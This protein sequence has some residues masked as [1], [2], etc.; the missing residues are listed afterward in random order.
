M[1]GPFRSR[2]SATL[3]C[4]ASSCVSLFLACP[5]LAADLPSSAQHSLKV[6]SNR[7]AGSSAS[8]ALFDRNDVPRAARLAKLETNR[9]PRRVDGWF[10]A[11]ESASARN[12][13]KTELRSALDVCK[14]AKA[15]DPR[16]PIA[17]MRLGSF[18][19]NSDLLR[20]E[21]NQLEALAAGESVC[22]EAA[23]ETL[24]D[25][26]LD[27]LPDADV[28]TLSRRAG[29]LTTWTISRGGNHP[30]EQFEF[31]DAHVQL[32]DYFPRAATYEGATSFSA[33]AAGT[34]V[35]TGDLRGVKVSIDGQEVASS[36]LTLAAGNH[37]VKINFRA[38]EASPRIRILPAARPDPNWSNLRML[39]REVLYIRAADALAAGNAADAGLDLKNPEISAMTVA[40][41][42]LA[43]ATNQG[44][45]AGDFESAAGHP[46]CGNLLAALS[47]PGEPV[48]AEKLQSCAPDSL[49][50][51]RWLATADRHADVIHELQ[52]VL[53]DWPLDREAHR[54][55]I[56]ELQRSGNAVAADRAAAAFLS[57]APNARNFRRMAQT[58]AMNEPPAS[59]PFY[60]AYRRPAPSKLSESL[61]APAVILLQDKVA[62][63]RVDGSVS[64]YVHR[65]VQL[66]TSAGA[67]QFQSLAL[68]EGGQLLAARVVNGD[69]AFP[70]AMKP[71]DE[72][73]EEYVVNYT[74]DGGMIAHP[75]A[76]QYVFHDFDYPLLNA[77][78]VVLSPAA[79]SPG[80]VIASGSV[81]EATEGYANGFRAQ[82]WEKQ[83]QPTAAATAD[84][85]II[86]VVENENGWSI[87]PSVERRRILE[88]IHPG[89]RPREA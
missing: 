87:P 18:G 58:A 26:A 8:V 9:F 65:V 61:D 33:P 79:E 10:L 13:Q 73:E 70:A 37:E 40:Q 15:D 23:T 80:Y 59:T 51:A 78:F 38:A 22:S 6:I 24:Y 25:A 57:V 3:L 56:A 45:T 55:L 82:V 17:A 20:D 39:R 66:M 34:Y 84:P 30:A 54:M 11:M 64:L 47:S 71:G 77:R 21:R 81:P 19:Q 31:A 29:W 49:A 69:H 62:I 44:S 75:E 48:N 12:D 16:V 5:S 32:P 76:F 43:Q 63:T 83:V 28:R 4:V 72:I 60:E 42:L 52:R 46:S 53:Q 35:V 14:L 1:N 88:T 85:G 67:E 41:K 74:G 86:R 50:Y 68:P 7:Q 89:P 36:P 2:T 27:G